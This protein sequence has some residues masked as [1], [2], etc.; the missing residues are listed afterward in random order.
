MEA[1][2]RELRDSERQ[3]AGVMRSRAAENTPARARAPPESS[4]R[5]GA[6]LGPP[7]LR[8][9][10]PDRAGAFFPA[11]RLPWSVRRPRMTA[12]ARG[13][14]R[15]VALTFF[16]ADGAEVYFGGAER[17]LLELS[18]LLASMGYRTELVQRARFPWVRYYRGLRVV[19]VVPDS[20]DFSLNSVIRRTLRRRPALTIYLAFYL[21]GTDCPPGSV[22]ISHGI[23]WDNPAFQGA[24]AE[25]ERHLRRILDSIDGLERIVSV[26]TNTINWA[27]ATRGSLV[28]KFTYI[29]NF[30]DRSEFHPTPRSAPR[31][32]VLYPRRLSVER[33]FWL[34]AEIVPRLIE[35]RDDLDFRFAGNGDPREREAVERLSSRYPGR[36]LWQ[37][38][39]PEAMP[40]E[41]ASADIVVIPTVASEGTSLSCLEAQASGKPVIA[42]RVGGLPD[43]VI[44]GVNG[45]L[46][47]PSSAGLRA[48]IERL[49]GAP[50]L[51]AA[52]G[53]N[54]RAMSA[55]FSIE[56]WRDRWRNVLRTHLPRRS[57]AACAWARR[58]RL[59]ALFPAP[60]D[61]SAGGER[62]AVASAVARMGIDVFWVGPEAPPTGGPR[63]HPVAPS[64]AVHLS[65][66]LVFVAEPAEAQERRHPGS[67]TIVFGPAS[68]PGRGARLPPSRPPRLS[69][70]TS[71][72]RPG[73]PPAPATGDRDDRARIRP[74]R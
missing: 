52:L 73:R 50:E 21:A 65:R 19:G 61:P 29:P 59:T 34:L 54:A 1:I 32:V 56:T 24:P 10:R 64:V 57:A 68:G 9:S 49:V 22:G 11:A 14:V 51:R 30:V 6:P 63:L 70:E 67:E 35:E 40:A 3:L 28:D 45:L 25:F 27:R 55:S 15:I 58:P 72:V 60:A 31:I 46:I 44:D 41:Y 47:E 20:D 33:G 36:I 48:A 71:S 16:D 2:R 17:Y 8:R 18:D 53:D 13:W 12:P 37:A 74:R 62:A 4:A 7:A 26:D 43:V 5:P 66:P 23:Y 39:P 38:I 42:T 69:C